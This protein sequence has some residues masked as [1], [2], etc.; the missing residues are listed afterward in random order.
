[1][2]QFTPL[3]PCNVFDEYRYQRNSIQSDSSNCE[4]DRETQD[5]RD[6]YIAR[7]GAQLTKDVAVEV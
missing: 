6:E 7:S 1:M 5:T 4:G 2:I 3:P